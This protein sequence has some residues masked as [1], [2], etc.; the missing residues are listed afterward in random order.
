MYTGDWYDVWSAN[1][2]VVAEAR[3][4]Q[5]LEAVQEAFTAGMGG[6]PPDLEWWAVVAPGPAGPALVRLADRP[7]D[8]LVVGWTAKRSKVVRYCLHNAGCPTM[9]VPP[10]PLARVSPRE[11]LRQSRQLLTNARKEARASG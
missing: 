7:D 3:Q 1:A 8:L 4:E 5:A 10:P 6:P 2:D 11:V 9:V